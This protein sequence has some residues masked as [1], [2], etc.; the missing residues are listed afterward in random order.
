MNA[1]SIIAAGILSLL[2]SVRGQA[3]L[4]CSLM[5]F[6]C[7][8]SLIGFLTS[9]RLKAELEECLQKLQSMPD[10]EH[11]QA[12][13]ALGE[14]EGKL[15]HYPKFRWVFPVFYSLTSAAFLGLLAYRLAMGRP[16]GFGL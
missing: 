5:V 1:H 8:F 12:Y 6:M 7:L 3:V 15:V 10:L 9:F 13:V 4:E 11:L 16:V 2:N 14:S